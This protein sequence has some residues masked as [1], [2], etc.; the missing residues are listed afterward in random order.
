MLALKYPAAAAIVVVI[1]VGLIAVF[2]AWIVRAIRRRWR[3]PVP[4]SP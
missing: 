3:R 4:A 1:G 2:A